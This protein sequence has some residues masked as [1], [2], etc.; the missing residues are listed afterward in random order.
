MIDNNE[1]KMEMKANYQTDDDEAGET[2]TMEANGGFLKSKKIYNSCPSRTITNL[3][4]EIRGHTTVV[5]PVRLKLHPCTRTYL[6]RSMVVV[7][8]VVGAT[9]LF[10]KLKLIQISHYKNLVSEFIILFII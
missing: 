2:T 3:N 8:V 1:S 10:S 9:P 4:S 6:V 7:V 5:H